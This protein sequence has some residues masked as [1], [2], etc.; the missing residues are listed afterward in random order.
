MK[1]APRFREQSSLTTLCTTRSSFLPL[2]LKRPWKCN[3][4][5]KTQ[6][7]VGNS[8]KAGLRLSTGC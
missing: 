4:K 1:P 6:K 7:V 2:Y 8:L 5:N 3:R